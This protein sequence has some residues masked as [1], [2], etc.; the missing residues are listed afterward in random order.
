MLNVRRN[1]L[2]DPAELASLADT[3]RLE[4]LAIAGN[5]WEAVREGGDS[6]R[7]PP[8]AD[9]RTPQED[10]F[11]DAW[12]AAKKRL[13]CLKRVDMQK[14][15]VQIRSSGSAPEGRASPR[16]P[17]SRTHPA[18][19]A[20]DTVA[21]AVSRSVAPQ[22]GEDRASCSCKEGNPVRGAT[23]GAVSALLAPLNIRRL[24][25]P[26]T[27]VQCPTTARTGSTGSRWRRRH[28]RSVTTKFS[29]ATPHSPRR[30]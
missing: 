2:K 7:P 10:S 3:K 5:P 8:G 30:G 6:G 14:H 25:L 11:Q 4:D 17:Y 9:P 23:G 18:T 28:E 22:L 19:V 15:T 27:S 13:P 29:S 20:G 12:A 16:W 1:E 24:S 26:R 21:E